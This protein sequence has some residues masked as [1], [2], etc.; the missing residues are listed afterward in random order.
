MTNQYRG[1]STRWL[2]AVMISAA[3]AISYFDRQSLSVA[4]KAIQRDI[5]VSD[6]D[7]A[8]L[9]TAFLMAYGIM[10]A[11]GGK[12]TDV[13]GTKRGFFLIMVW[14]SLACAGHGLAANFT[15]LAGC[16][17]LLGMGEGG[18]FPAATRAVAEWFP[19]QRTINCHGHNQRRY[20]RWRRH[21]R[22]S[23]RRHPILCRMALGFFH[24]RVHR[25]LVDAYGGF[26]HTTFLP[27]IRVYRM[28]KKRGSKRSSP[29]QTCPKNPASAG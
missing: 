24:I 18:G 23:H 28:L 14:W 17:L 29:F 22:S 15:M 3:I 4:V 1:I 21:R 13:L 20:C 2:I 16:R 8:R 7:F 26:V 25:S 12:I 10:Y 5:P 9:Q 27:G 19:V 11:I 6:P